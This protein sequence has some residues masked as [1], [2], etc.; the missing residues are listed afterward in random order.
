MLKRD[1]ILNKTRCLLNEFINPIIEKADKPRKKFLHQ[2]IG[3]I[4]LSGSLIVT[5]LP[6]GYLH[7]SC[8]IAVTT[9]TNL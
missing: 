6:T 5:D 1:F 8:L 7:I 3:A 9:L 2:A 4:L